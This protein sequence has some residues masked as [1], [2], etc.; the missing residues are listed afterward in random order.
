MMNTSLLHPVWQRVFRQAWV[1]NLVLFIALGGLRAYGLFGPLS[2][3]LLI[4]LGFLLMCFLP[5]IFYAQSGRYEMGLRKVERPIWLLW[6][7]LIGMGGSFIIFSV[8]YGFFG[9]SANN[10]YISILNS[11]AIDSTMMQLPRIQLFLIYTL[12]AMLVSP[13][14]E[15]FFFRGM[16]H[17]SVNQLWGQRAAIFINALAFGSVH[18]LHHGLSWDSTG[19]HFLLVSGLLW[20]VLMMGMSWFFT[21]CR[22][23][24]DSIWPAVVAHSAFNLGMN[25]T[26]FLILF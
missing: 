19:M 11:W 8:G 10:W 4:M 26:I 12:P 2:A 15:E 20:V 14:G 21:Q 9:R 22:Q 24:G 17:E 5:F 18:I 23:R 6:G 3:R 25:L 7:L 13:V 1:L 16:I